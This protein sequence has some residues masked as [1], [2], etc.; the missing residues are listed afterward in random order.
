MSILT[1]FNSDPVYTGTGRIWDRSEIRPFSPVYTLIRPV[2]GSLQF[3]RYRISGRFQ[4]RPRSRVNGVSVV[5]AL[6][7]RLREQMTL[8]YADDSYN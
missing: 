7:S 1:I 8:E 3:V 6:L 4:I 2:R 5:V